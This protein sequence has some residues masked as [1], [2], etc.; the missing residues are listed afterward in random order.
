MMLFELVS[1]GRYFL[2]ILL[3]ES[4]DGGLDF[5]L[6]LFEKSF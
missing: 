2:F 1:E 6:V 4:T 3:S 5:M